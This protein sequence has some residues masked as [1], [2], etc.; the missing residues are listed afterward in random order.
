MMASADASEAIK[1]VA[2]EVL[3][4]FDGISGRVLDELARSAM[5]ADGLANLDA[6]VVRRA[7]ERR[8]SWDVQRRSELHRLKDEPAIARVVARDTKG[9]KH[10]YYICRGVPPSS[11]GVL[12]ASQRA[13]VGRLAALQPGDTVEL[14]RPGTLEVLENAELQPSRDRIG[15]DSAPTVFRVLRRRALTAGSLRALLNEARP[16]D[17]DPMALLEALP[18]APTLVEGVRRAVIRQMTLR[19]QPVLDA[20]QDEIFRMPLR[21][22]L[23]LMGPPG[24]GKTTTLVRRVGQKLD[25]IHLP[26]DELRLSERLS[27]ESG[28]EHRQNWLMFTPTALLKDYVREAFNREDV[29]ASQRLMKTWSEYRL[30]LARHQL[31]LLRTGERKSGFVLKREGSHLRPAIPEW[32]GW[33]EDFAAWQVAAW[34]G[35]LASATE[36][37]DSAGGVAQTVGRQARLAIAANEDAVSLALALADQAKAAQ[38]EAAA[39]D[40]EIR[41]QLRTWG[42][43]QLRRDRDFAKKLAD[44][45]DR[46]RAAQEA[47]A[48]DDDEADDEEGEP[49][50]AAAASP[51]RELEAIQRGYWQVLRTVARARASGRT[52]PKASTSGKLLAWLGD[53]LPPP[54]ELTALGKRLQVQSALRQVA[55]PM[56]GYLRAVPRH[57][58]EFRR[59]RQTEGRWY[60]DGALA[61]TD[62]DADELDLL[63]ALLLRRA[64]DMLRRATV[65]AQI[66][67]P[68]WSALRP[69]R[70]RLL[71]QVLVDEATDFSPL[72]LAAMA[73]L[74]HPDSDAFFASGDFNQRLTSW[75]TRS[76]DELAWAVPGTTIRHVDVPYRQTRRLSEFSRAILHATGQTVAGPAGTDSGRWGQSEGYA[77]VLAEGLADEAVLAAWLAERI[78]EVERNVQPGTSIAVL[79]PG[80]ERVV[81]L[82]EAL[83]TRL[84]AVN[85]EVQACRAGQTVGVSHA[86]RVFDLQHIK[87]LEFEAVFL[88]G[89]DTLAERYPDLF[90]KYLYVGATRAAN[91]LGLACA[92]SLPKTLDV[93]RGQFIRS[94]PAPT[95]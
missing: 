4:A 24:T 48:D 23:A 95:A 16:E 17:D 28:R 6:E 19:D 88:V 47:A 78:V 32:R 15:W 42:A 86:V 20:I 76:E 68:V 93:L 9:R 33:Y 11:T 35:Q 55:S 2:R 40:A 7:M 52:V 56:Q 84:A 22:R 14:E 25:S 21:S 30:D 10:T 75:G 18:G 66:D 27:A 53:R 70:D 91:C 58:R 59:E 13:P 80:E 87:G 45:L 94:W 64:K 44:E 90:D 65:R 77:P 1:P 41:K 71:A 49:P 79:V 60:A 61:G 12:L 26:E 62:L 8:D 81:P 37:L 46:L 67:Q 43:D 69:F 51:N 36:V 29:A 3:Q 89:L 39:M 92:G 38:A 34:R 63:V 57:Y 31:G 82:A 72:Q 54:K 83:Q 74:V 50:P 5:T 73:A 85:L